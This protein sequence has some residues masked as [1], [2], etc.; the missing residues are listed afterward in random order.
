MIGVGLMYGN[1]AGGGVAAAG[2]GL[3]VTGYNTVWV[4]IAGITLIVAGL[5]VMRLMPRR[6]VRA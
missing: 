6:R 4:L 5:A 3:A 1:V 2:T